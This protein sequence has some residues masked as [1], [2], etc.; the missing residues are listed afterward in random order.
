VSELRVVVLT[1]SYPRHA[2]DV[3]GAFVRDGVEELRRAGVHVGVVSP[4]DFRH[5]GIAYGHGIVNN[6]RAAPWKLLALPLFMFSFAR[7]ARRAARD[8]DIVH[9][10]WLPSALPS[11]ATGKPLVIQLWGSD[12]ALARRMRPLAR[13]VLR[14]ASVV[15]CASTALAR[16]ATELG[17]RRVEVVPSGVS[18]PVSV[19]EPEEPPHALYV[20]RLSEEKGVRELAEATTGLPL[21]IVGDGP[22][23]S[24][25][26]RAIGFLPPSDLGPYYERAAVVV[27]PSRR[28]GYGVVAREAMAF[29]RPVVAT[30]VG[31]LIDAVTDGVTGLLVRPRDPVALRNAIT[32]LL[33]DDEGR[34]RL[35]E[36][37]RAYAIE[38]LSWT[39]YSRA[40]REV[41]DAACA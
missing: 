38:R 1:T 5:F 34:M 13:L 6:L 9:A 7:A 17:A 3:A 28:E 26:P 25:F 36:A 8:A 22:L 19:G 15:V 40:V 21:V 33:A 39:E 37:A 14:R 18:I 30:A 29:G 10:H 27:V 41:Y 12:V 11:L 35:G 32:Q 2:G 16:E 24:L 20:G 4:A 31:G 23:R